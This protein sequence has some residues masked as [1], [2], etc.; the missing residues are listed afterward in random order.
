MEG[1]EAGRINRQVKFKFRQGLKAIYNH[2]SSFFT[3]FKSE[4]MS[5]NQR[6]NNLLLLTFNQDEPLLTPASGCLPSSLQMV[7]G[8]NCVTTQGVAVHPCLSS[9]FLC[10]LCG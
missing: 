1:M 9:V 5:V 6:L 2:L 7:S 8:F 4:S 10:V 3:V